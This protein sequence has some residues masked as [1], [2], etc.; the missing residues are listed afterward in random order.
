[1]TWLARTT[2]FFR[3]HY[4]LW[5]NAGHLEIGQPSAAAGARSVEAIRLQSVV[6]PIFQSLIKGP[7]GLTSF[8]D[9]PSRSITIRD[10]F[11]LS[12]LY[13]CSTGHFLLQEGHFFKERTYCSIEFFIEKVEGF[14][15]FSFLFPWDKGFFHGDQ[16][17]GFFQ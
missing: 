3:Y 1:M 2:E 14:I 16:G 17:G 5:F 13:I 4:H 9:L 12:H 6:T 11:S 10:C 7:A 8:S 15:G